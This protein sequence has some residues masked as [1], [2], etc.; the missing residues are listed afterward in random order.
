MESKFDLLKLFVNSSSR[1]YLNK[2]CQRFKFLFDG[3]YFIKV[4]NGCD[5]FKKI[6]D[7][8]SIYI[9]KRILGK[10]LSIPGY[11]EY[12]F[13][14]TINNPRWIIRKDKKIIE[15]HGFIIKPTSNSS[16]LV[17][18]FCKVL[19][20]L[21]AFSLIAPYKVVISD[22]KIKSLLSCFEINNDH[23]LGIIYTGAPGKFQKFTL[24]IH[25]DK[26]QI[27]DFI[28]LGMKPASVARISNE[29]KALLSIQ[30]IEFNNV[31]TPRLLGS[32]HTEVYKGIRVRNILN[33]KDKKITKLIDADL[34]FLKALTKTIKICRVNDDLCDILIKNYRIKKFLIIHNIDEIEIMFSHGDYT[35]FNRFTNSSSLKIIDWETAS[36]RPLYY[37][38]YFFLFY[39]M[40]IVRSCT[41]K[42][43][44]EYCYK[45]TKEINNYRKIFSS[46]Q[47]TNVY[48]CLSL[49]EII[50]HFKTNE[51]TSDIKPIKN[52]ERIFNELIMQID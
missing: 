8:Y 4:I 13:F 27:S 6:E 42:D 5:E 49:I 7:P 43:Y 23:K 51:N 21:N 15:N 20:K 1:I 52:A 30:N 18:F 25:K 9:Y 29:E 33:N 17:W 32:F 38:L 48:I 36:F 19:N 12:H 37:D 14:P 31:I 22:K 11:S 40:F 39:S 2:N 50:S 28:K 46:T 3:T 16:R 47:N 10:N 34:N 44:L 26:N 41:V 24:Q 35:L 45:L